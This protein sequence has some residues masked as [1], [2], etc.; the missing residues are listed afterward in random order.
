LKSILGPYVSPCWRFNLTSK[1]AR[2]TVKV[3]P[4]PS[5]GGR[6]RKFDLIAI[7]TGSVMETVELMLKDNPKL[8]VAVVDKD[9]PGGICLTR[10]CIPSKILLYSAELVR[11]IEEASKFGVNAELKG[12]DFAYIMDRMRAMIGSEIEM[13]RRGLSQ[14]DNITFY[15]ATATFVEPYVLEVGGQLI[16]APRIFLGA[17]SKPHVPP[18]SGLCDAGYMTSD[19]VIGMRRKP[20]S[21]IVVGGGYIAAEYGHFFS[22]MGVDVTVVGRNPRF[23]PDEEP[24]I[25]Q[26]AAMILS[27][28]MKILVNH[29]VFKVERLGSN[30]KKVYSR[31]R[32]TGA[33]KSFEAEEILVAAGRAPTT[34]ILHP[35]RGGVETDGEGWIKTDEYLETTQKN[36]WALGDATGKYMFKHKANYDAVILYYNAA[37]GR[38]VRVDY[39]AVPHAVFTYPEVASVGLGEKQAVD[40]YGEDKVLVGVERY[41]DTAKGEAM[42]VSQCFAKILVHADDYRILGAHIVGPYASTLIQEIVNLMYTSNPSVEVLLDAIH[43]HPALSEVVQRAAGSLTTIPEYHHVLEHHYGLKVTP[44]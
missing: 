36:V 31:D 21:L 8:R 42:G 16:T 4:K 14:S 22:A 27:R 12:I 19:D 28:H 25:S 32:S 1:A 38:R 24:E 43:I 13:I 26:V 23:L 20:R 39:S 11:L 34:D 35:E 18:I 3:E 37:L 40:R 15:N 33:V 2:S 44:H 41:E 29:E 30:L 7:G 5:R 10:G 6:P 17:G 9:T